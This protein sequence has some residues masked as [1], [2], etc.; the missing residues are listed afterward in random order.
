MAK[1]GLL[2]LNLGTPRSPSVPHVRSYLREFLM[3]PRVIDTPYLSRFLLVNAI[4]APFRASKSSEAY[5]SIWMEEGSPLLVHSQ[6]LANAMR[7]ILGVP[8]E[9]AMRYGE[10][11]IASALQTLSNAG[12][13]LLTVLPLFPHY[14][15][16]SYESAVE[17]AK[18]HAARYRMRVR[19][20]E[21]FYADPGYIGALVARTK[22]Y[23]DDADHLLFSFHGVPERH[24]TKS[25]GS[26]HCLQS[27]GC[28]EREHAAHNTCYRHQCFETVKAFVKNCGL[29]EDRYSVAFQSRLG[30]AEWLKPATDKHLIELAAKG[31]K[32]LAVICPSFTADC[33]ETLEEIGIRGKESFVEAGGESLTL[34]PCLNEDDAWIEQV[35]RMYWKSESIALAS[36]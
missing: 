11:S 7:R 19:Y 9:L 16:S 30:R 8:V 25:D 13:D 5:N 34:V 22:P 12:I 14:A 32:R 15:M 28:C 6:N 2:L 3:D 31:V 36:A 26:N 35:V 23:L 20:V 21:P 24:L 1:S 17:A 18:S 10:P 29:A 27:A 33:L 4:I